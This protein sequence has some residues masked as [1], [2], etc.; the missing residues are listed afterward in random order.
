[1]N[2]STRVMQSKNHIIRK[3]LMPL[4]DKALRIFFQ[5]TGRLNYLAKNV[6]MEVIQ[7]KFL[8]INSLV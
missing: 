6:E 7:D 1:M 2:D 5:N 3:K 4:Y 8:H